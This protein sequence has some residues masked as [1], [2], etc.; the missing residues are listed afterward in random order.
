MEGLS[1]S[2]KRH[3]AEEI[4][5]KLRQAQAELGRERSVPEVCRLL[6]VKEATCRWLV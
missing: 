5:N 2:R 6:G 4:V 1:M 3:P